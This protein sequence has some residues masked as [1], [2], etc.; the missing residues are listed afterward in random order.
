[1]GGAS[2]TIISFDCGYGI[3]QVTSGMH[4]GENPGFDRA[5]VAGDPTYNLATG[6]Q[7]LAAKWRATQCVGDNQ[8]RDRG[9]VHRGVGLQRA[10][11]HQQPHQPRTYNANRGVWNPA[12]GCPDSDP[13]QERVFGYLEHPPTAAHWSPAGGR[14]SR[15]DGGIGLGTKPPDLKRAGVR[16]DRPTA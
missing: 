7:I 10:R 2:R 5:R 6:T 14:L 13:Y 1:M 4:A 9:L 15:T 12:M 16:G 8:P 3:G 11:V